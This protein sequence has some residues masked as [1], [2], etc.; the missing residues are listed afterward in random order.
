MGP[1]PDRAALE[2]CHDALRACLENGGDPA[3][4]F[5]LGH[6]CIRDAFQAAFQA[7]CNEV[8]AKCSNGEIPAD[9]CVAVVERCT[10]GVA[11]PP[12]APAQPQ[13]DASQ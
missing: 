1:G 11:P 12:D 8:T 5:E 2:A 10:Q 6:S 13:C 4:C 7:R 3:A 9:M